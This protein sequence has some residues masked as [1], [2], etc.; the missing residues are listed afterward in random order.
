MDSRK[1]VEGSAGVADWQVLG[2]IVEE[3]G[4]GLGRKVVG[5]GFC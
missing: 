1:R 5:L 4:S 3:K 2:Y